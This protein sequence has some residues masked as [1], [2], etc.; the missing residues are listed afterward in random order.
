MR[1]I[2]NWSEEVESRAPGHGEGDLIKGKGNGSS[3]GTLGES[4]SRRMLH[5]RL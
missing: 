1:L 2:T 3:I 5:S 4:N